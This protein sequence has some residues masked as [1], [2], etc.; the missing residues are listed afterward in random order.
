MTSPSRATRAALELDAH[1]APAVEQVYE[2][3]AAAA[4]VRRLGV[5]VEVIITPDATLYILY[6]DHL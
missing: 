2:D 1:A 4:V 3:E 6:G 5:D